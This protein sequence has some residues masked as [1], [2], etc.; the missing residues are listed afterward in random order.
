MYLPLTIRILI[1]TLL[2]EDTVERTEE[3][4]VCIIK[5]RI[6]VCLCQHLNPLFNCDKKSVQNVLQK[7]FQTL[8]ASSQSYLQ[9]HMQCAPHKA[10]F[11]YYS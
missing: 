8:A 2:G 6:L 3:L 7:L 4:C 9:M 11:S 5:Y 10:S 1:I